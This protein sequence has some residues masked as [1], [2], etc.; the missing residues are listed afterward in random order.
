MSRCH[1]IYEERAFLLALSKPSVLSKEGENIAGEIS[2]TTLDMSPARWPICMQQG[3]A[4]PGDKNIFE[5]R[6]ETHRQPRCADFAGG[7]VSACVSSIKPAPEDKHAR[8]ADRITLRG[9]NYKGRES[10]L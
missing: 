4:Y 8:I 5:G 10:Q 1:A 9:G 3:R 6:K 7:A 2:K